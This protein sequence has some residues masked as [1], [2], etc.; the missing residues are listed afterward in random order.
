MN[1]AMNYVPLNP[2]PTLPSPAP[3][4]YALPVSPASTTRSEISTSLSQDLPQPSYEGKIAISCCVGVYL[5][6]AYILYLYFGEANEGGYTLLAWFIFSVVSVTCTVVL[7]I[8]GLGHVQTNLNIDSVQLI[9]DLGTQA[10]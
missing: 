7:F 8:R 5:L 10:T 1:M 6:L 2:L 9:R 3:Q 4:T